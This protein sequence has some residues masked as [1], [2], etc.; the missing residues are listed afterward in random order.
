[1]EKEFAARVRAKQ[2]QPGKKKWSV[3]EAGYLRRAR[4]I[5]VPI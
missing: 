2:A 3:E 4:G 1:M 5:N